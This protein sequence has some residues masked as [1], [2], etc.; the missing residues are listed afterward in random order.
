MKVKESFEEFANETMGRLFFGNVGYEEAELKE[1]YDQ[2]LEFDINNLNQP[3]AHIGPCSG[4]TS[5]NNANPM[6]DIEEARE[7]FKPTI[8]IKPEF[9]D[10]KPQLIG[11]MKIKGD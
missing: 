5:W 10:P 1:I 6:E 4:P 8:D 3:T 2:L 11:Y 7:Y 9:P